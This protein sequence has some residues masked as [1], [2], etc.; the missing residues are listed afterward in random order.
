MNMNS[1]NSNKNNHCHRSLFDTAL[2]GLFDIPEARTSYG[3][4]AFSMAEPWIKIGHRS[5]F[6]W[7][8]FESKLKYLCWIRPSHINITSGYQVVIQNKRCF[9]IFENPGCPCIFENPGCSCIFENPGC[10]CIFENP[11]CP[12]IF[13]NPGCPCIFENPGCPC[14][15][16]NPGVPAFLRIL[17]VPAFLRIL[18]V[19]AFLG[20]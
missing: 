7:L 2:S 12:C 5:K 11:G 4:W 15:F 8:Y 9:C 6:A 1:K 19:P 20:P 18:G 16:E 13:E 3:T 10:P 14:I 17:S